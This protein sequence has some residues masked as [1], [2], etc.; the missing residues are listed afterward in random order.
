MIRHERRHSATMVRAP[1]PP[2]P[3]FHWLL[4]NVPEF[5]RDMLAF[6]ERLSREYGDVVSYRLGRRRSVLLTHPDHI[7]QVLVTDN[8][9]F[10]KHFALRLLRPTLGDGL[11]L[12]E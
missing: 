12:S 10:I 4:G 1:D 5:R 3:P 9:N 2:G 6:Y 8:R 7:E 11:L